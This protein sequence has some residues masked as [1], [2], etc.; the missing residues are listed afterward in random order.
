MASAP[1]DL[2]ALAEAAAPPP[3][4]PPAPAIKALSCPSCGGTINVKAAGYTVTVACI[5]CG[6]ILDVANP[7]VRLITE[8]RQAMAELE[9]P[10]GTRGVLRGVE[11]EAIG[12]T[13]RSEHGSYPW[14]EYLLFNPYQG[15]RW[16]I[17]N[18]R[19]WSF[20]EMLTRAPDWGTGGPLLD[21]QDY[22]PF[23]ADGQAQV[24]YVVG[25]FY[26]RVQVGEEV[27]TDDYVR[28]GFMLSR[29]A[30]AQEVSWTLSALLEPDE[31]RDAFGVVPN[32]N[33]WPPLP[34]QPSPYRAVMKTG[35]KIGLVMLAV[36]FVLTVF[37]SGGPT[38]VDGTVPFTL[39]GQQRTAT[40]GPLT[41]T[42]PYQLVA[43][44]AF[45]PAVENGWIDLDYSLV[46]RA[47]Q[48]SYEAYGIA[49]RYSGSDSD[50]P[51]TEGSRGGTV[52][53]A[54]VPAGTYDLIV[55]YTGN[56]WTGS[57]YSSYGGYTTYDSGG[58]SLQIRV[59]R[60]GIF[61]SNFFLAAI[62]ILLPLLWFG[63]QHIRFE[64]ARQ[65]E[66]DVGRTGMAK[67][68]TGSDEEDEEDE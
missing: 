55:E 56:R 65:D 3:P 46:N 4:A 23:F 68:F 39:D 10:L 63:W 53:L 58:G 31:I 45:A 66:S 25:E 44:R 35:A 27:A 9:I 67:L 60:G 57:S 8:Y 5:Y 19:G 32:P 64:Q 14:D 54:A 29:E 26:W 17:T 15:Y 24:D 38:L 22:A 51:W 41:V 59:S 40:I 43:I 20:G 6:S 11:W 52:K 1:P 34:H 47:T 30:N 48:D 42:R 61:P 21:G 33:P 12:Y 7:Q 18:G 13:R 28:P 37:M 36:L 16:L 62:L 49:E 50:G 2:T